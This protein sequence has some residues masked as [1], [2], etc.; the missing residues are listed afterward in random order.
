M[1][2]SANYSNEEDKHF[3]QEEE[4]PLVEEPVT[5]PCIVEINTSEENFDMISSTSKTSL[6]NEEGIIIFVTLCYTV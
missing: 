2:E 5:V 1:T 4:P 3:E 6:D